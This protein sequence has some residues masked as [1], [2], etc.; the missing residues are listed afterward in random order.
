MTTQ[1]TILLIDDEEPLLEVLGRALTDSG[2]ICLRSSSADAALRLLDRT[3]EI[4]IIVSDIRMPRMDGIE[5]LRNIRQRYSDRKWLQVVFITGHA[6]VDNS[7]EALRLDAADFLYKP[8]RRHKL[9][10]AIEKAL[11]KGAA[12]RQLVERHERLARLI[13]EAQKLA[14]IIGG[15]RSDPANLSAHISAT[16]E[17]PDNKGKNQLD[18][19]RLLKLLRTRDIKTQY[20]SDRL[21]AD[22]AWHM[23]LDLMENH[24]LQRNVSVSSLYL[25][26]GVAAATASRRLDEMVQSQLVE[27]WLDPTDRRRQF[28]RLTDGTVELVTNYLKAL[29]E[30]VAG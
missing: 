6:T 15:A 13:D 23:I 3:P 27:R 5:L 29:D 1:S 19:A 4:D 14:S 21:F 28:V 7:V 24:L 20:F 10:Q 30:K 22:P 16:A 8:V 9:L 18:T 26:S 11:E 12:Q 17:G 25:A 2:Y